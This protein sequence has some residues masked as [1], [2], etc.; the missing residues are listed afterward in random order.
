MKLKDARKLFKEIRE[1]DERISVRPHA[2]KDHPERKF[3][4]LE[5][6]R[7]IRGSGG[8]HDN[9]FPSAQPGSFLWICKDDD[10]RKTEIA[11]VFEASKTGELIVIIHAYREVQDENNNRK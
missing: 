1:V 2:W 8:L 7:L 6:V 10:G 5:L 4:A 11:I 9:N 3:T